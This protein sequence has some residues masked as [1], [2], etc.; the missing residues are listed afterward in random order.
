MINMSQDGAMFP[1][2]RLRRIVRRDSRPWYSP[3]NWQR[4][5]GNRL[6]RVADSEN[7]SA[8]ACSPKDKGIVRARV[9]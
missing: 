5:E 9:F 7:D 6:K 8:G 4:I 2:P 3:Q 1:P